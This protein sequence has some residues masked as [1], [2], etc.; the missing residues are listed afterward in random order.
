MP[1]LGERIDLPVSQL[2]RLVGVGFSNFQSDDEPI[3][4]D[5]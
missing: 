5:G 3:E 1:E 2:F 4:G